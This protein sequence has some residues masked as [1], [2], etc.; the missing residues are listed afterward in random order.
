MKQIISFLS[1]TLLKEEPSCKFMLKYDIKIY[2][3]QFT[4]NLSICLWWNTAHTDL[5]IGNYFWL[6]HLN[7]CA[8]YVFLSDKYISFIGWSI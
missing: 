2:F 7:I 4:K 5:V 8:K 3:W 1:R 6:Q